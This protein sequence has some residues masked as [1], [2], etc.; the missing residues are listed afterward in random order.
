MRPQ[1]VDRA[2]TWRH[3][4]DLHASG[5][6]TATRIGDR[7]SEA[8]HDAGINYFGVWGWD[9]SPRLPPYPTENYAA[10]SLSHPQTEC[11]SLSS[12]SP[13][14]K[15]STPDAPV[16]AE[17]GAHLRHLRSVGGKMHSEDPLAGI[18]STD[19]IEIGFVISG[20]I[21]IEPDTG[22]EVTSSGQLSRPE[23]RSARLAQ[24]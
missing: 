19:S 1:R 23:R 16:D 10:S 17:A 4:N 8:D 14:R 20:E 2:V 3:S 21:D 13:R 22:A 5:P 9:A 7:G 24:P 18:H 6:L 15:G 11:A 12:S